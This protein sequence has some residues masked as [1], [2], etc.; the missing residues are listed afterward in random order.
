MKCKIYNCKEEALDIPGDTTGV[1]RKHDNEISIISA[2]VHFKRAIKCRNC[3]AIRS[4]EGAYSWSKMRWAVICGGR[5][6]IENKKHEWLPE[7]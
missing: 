3:G 6:C 7:K 4:L 2:G 1:C 5:K